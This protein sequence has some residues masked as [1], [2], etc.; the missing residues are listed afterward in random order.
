MCNNNDND[1]DNNSNRVT[2]NKVDNDG[3]I[4]MDG[5]DNGE[6][7]S[8]TM[9]M[10]KLRQDATTRTMSNYVNGRQT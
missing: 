3:N 10:K 8:A 2:G 5:N 7:N 9:T 4:T 6:D 1:D